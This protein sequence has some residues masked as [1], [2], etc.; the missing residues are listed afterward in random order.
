MNKAEA[1][2]SGCL[3]GIISLILVVVGTSFIS[4]YLYDAPFHYEELKRAASPNARKHAHLFTNTSKQNSLAPYSGVSLSRDERLDR[5]YE[6]EV[7]S[8]QPP[9][10]LASMELSWLDNETLELKFRVNPDIK[11][12]I[13]YGQ[14]PAHL[15]R[16]VIFTALS[17]EPEP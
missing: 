1:I 16:R 11:A 9:S 10:A 14:P 17:K 6:A 5:G 15:C 7:F 2:G 3:T 12:R 8:I 13:H 4:N